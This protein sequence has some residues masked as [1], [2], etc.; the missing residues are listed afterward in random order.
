MSTPPV[1]S[2]LTEL[3]R[4]YRIA[5]DPRYAE[6]LAA[7]GLKQDGPI[8]GF[9]FVEFSRL[10]YRPV[11]GGDCALIVPAFDDGVLADLVACRIT[12]RRIATRYG[13]ARALG[14]NEVDRAI[15]RK[16]RLP[17]YS[18]PLRWLVNDRRGAVVLD[19]SQTG[20]LLDGVKSIGCDSAALA[21]RVD[22][23]LGAARHQRLSRK[24]VLSNS[25]AS[26]SAIPG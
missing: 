13:A 16:T 19:W 4:A 6:S 17:L 18:D 21:H 23:A 24:N 11:L 25:P 26:R 7:C 12:D 3:L 9:D 20:R 5:R 1:S 2:R 22:A 10:T 14:E 8:W 15:L